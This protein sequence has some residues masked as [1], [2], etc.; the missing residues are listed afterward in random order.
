MEIRTCEQFVLAVLENKSREVESLEKKL[1]QAIA[2]RDAMKSKADELE[3]KLGEEP[4]T[5][6]AAVIKT[7]RQNLFHDCTYATVTDVKN[8]DGE[9]IPFRV[10]CE[11]AMRDY[12]RPKGVSVSEFIKFFEPEFREA[13]EEKM[14]EVTE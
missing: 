14:P 7:G 3:R 5:M 11:E 6:E 13:Y 1:S 8:R 4:N 12:G 10:W 9:V 2:E